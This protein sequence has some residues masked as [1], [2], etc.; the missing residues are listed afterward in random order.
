MNCQ[1]RVITEDNVD[2]LMS[3]T[4]GDDIKL[5][6]FNNL[7]EV[8]EK[9]EQNNTESNRL[10]FKGMRE[11]AVIDYEKLMEHTPT[12]EAIANEESYF[13]DERTLYNQS[14]DDGD[15]TDYNPYQMPA[16][17]RVLNQNEI[18][19]SAYRFNAGDIVVFE[20]DMPQY[21]YRIIEFDPEEM[22]YVTQAIEGPHEGK[23]RDSFYDDI[24]TP[25][26]RSQPYDPESPEFHPDTPPFGPKTPSYSPNNPDPRLK[27]VEQ[28]PSPEVSNPG[29]SPQPRNYDELEEE[30]FSDEEGGLAPVTMSPITPTPDNPSDNMSYERTPPEE[31]EEV[32]EKGEKILNRISSLDNNPADTKG[33]EKLSTIE[34]DQKDGEGEDGDGDNSDKKKIV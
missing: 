5:L 28:M 4:E 31:K 30:E 14:F 25:P 21:K 17:T 16:D 33:L 29:P 34:D 11:S 20:P 22:K 26:V 24:M 2:Q 27:N 8:A 32:N 9:T 15:F 1:M 19:K 23:Y 6:G 18:R 10:R 12:P 3:L 7:E 13:Q